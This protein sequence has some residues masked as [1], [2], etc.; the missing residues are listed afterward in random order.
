VASASSTY[1]GGNGCAL[2]RSRVAATGFEVLSALLEPL[3]G[4][5]K[6]LIVYIPLLY[7]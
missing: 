6:V 7:D 3:R 5:P 2:T 4:A 1:F